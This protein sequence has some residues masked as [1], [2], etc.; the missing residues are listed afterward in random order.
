MTKEVAVDLLLYYLHRGCVENYYASL[1][2]FKTNHELLWFCIYE[3]ITLHWSLT[4][5]KSEHKG[6]KYKSW[7]I[8]NLCDQKFWRELYSR[9][10]MTRQ[11]DILKTMVI[12]YCGAKKYPHSVGMIVSIPDWKAQIGINCAPVSALPHPSLSQKLIIIPSMRRKII[13]GNNIEKSF[14]YHIKRQV[15][16]GYLEGSVKELISATHQSSLLTAYEA[17][18]RALFHHYRKNFD[19]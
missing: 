18:I 13:K 3:T 11:S 12:R 10:W 9:I 2:K 15:K 5:S 16:E 19:L 6:R 4:I 8:E 1:I 14:Q 7:R 17:K